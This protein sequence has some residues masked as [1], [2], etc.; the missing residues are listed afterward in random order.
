MDELIMSAFWDAG[1]G[2]GD[3]GD[4]DDSVGGDDGGN[5]DDGD[6]GA[7]VGNGGDGD[8]VDDGDASDCDFG[9]CVS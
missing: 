2:A 6:G 7:A 8:D 3:R 9:G 1:T 5:G 4:G